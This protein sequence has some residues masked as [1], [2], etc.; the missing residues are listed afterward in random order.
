G[1]EA[2]GLRKASKNFNLNQIEEGVNFA[3]ERG[4]KVYVTLNIVPHDKDLEGLEKYVQALANIK[5]D[6]V[7]V[8]DP[9]M[10]AVI[11]R[12]VADLPIHIS[13]QASV[14]NYETIM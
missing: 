9:G 6:A 1:G 11:K 4:K 7:I 8:S 2:F 5:V 14:T 10:F 3:H 13:T 12:T